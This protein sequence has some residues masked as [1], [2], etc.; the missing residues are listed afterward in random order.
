MMIP[1]KDVQPEH[2]TE[3]Y[4]SI[5]NDGSLMC[6]LDKVN[7]KIEIVRKGV[8]TVIVFNEDGSIYLER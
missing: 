1:H 2:H 4:E 5:R 7:H 3:Y 6:R 8:T